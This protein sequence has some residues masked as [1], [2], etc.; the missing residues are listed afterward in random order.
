MYQ[1]SVGLQDTSMKTPVSRLQPAS[2]SAT[3]GAGA[4]QKLLRP[5]PMV[6]SS[7][8]ILDIKFAKS[9]YLG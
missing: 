1:G 3:H 2:I 6:R 4:N 7:H 5:I 9:H 8:L